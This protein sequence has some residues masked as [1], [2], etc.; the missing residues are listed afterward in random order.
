[1]SS[2]KLLN[3][4]IVIFLVIT[5]VGCSGDRDYAR[6]EALLFDQAEILGEIEESVERTLYHLRN[7]YGVEVVLAT[8]NST[9]GSETLREMTARLFTDWD[10]GRNYQG[11]GLLLLLDDDEKEARIEVGLALEGIFTDLFTGYIE[12]KQLKPYYLSGQLE[13]GLI[14]ILEE[15]EARANLMALGNASSESINGRDLKFLSAGGG[16]DVDLKEYVIDTVISK[17]GNYPAGETPEQAWQ[18]LLQSWRDKNRDPDVGIYTPATRLIYRSYTNQ[19]AQ[20]FED[21]VRTWGDKPYEIIN[22]D[23]YAVIFFGN[24]KGWENAPFLFCRTREGWQFDMVHQRKIVRM[25]RAPRWGSN[26]VSTHISVYYLD[27]PSGWGRTCHFVAMIYIT[28]TLMKIRYGL[29]S[30]LRSSLGGMGMI[31]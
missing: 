1:M 27:A 19:P 10:V 15:I 21:D 17:S 30:D 23:N 22:D 4:S 9:G 26:G 3:H 31:L 13:I 24:I 5:Q 2:I 12:N 16:A 7:D 18:I 29:F 8:V 6:P 20:R 11:Q 25:G 28:C 14:A